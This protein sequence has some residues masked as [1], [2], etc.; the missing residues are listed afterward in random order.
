MSVTTN[1]DSD[2]NRDER[3]LGEASALLE[4]DDLDEEIGHSEESPLSAQA[5]ALR[6]R[7]DQ[8]D[9]NSQYDFGCLLRDGVGVEKNFSESVRYFKMAADQG[10][11]DAQLNC[12]QLLES[13]VEPNLSEAARYYKLAADQGNRDAQ[14]AYALCLQ[15][16]KGVTKDSSEMARY[17]KLGADQDS[18]DCQLSY[19]WCLFTGDGVVKDASE[20]ARYFK[21][22]ADGNNPDGQNCFGCC[23]A[24]GIGVKRNLPE[25]VRYFKLS[26]DMGNADGQ[27]NFGLCR[28]LGLGMEQNE[29]E[30]VEYFKRSADKG[31]SGGQDS[32][33]W[34]LL[35]GIGLDGGRKSADDVE[36]AAQCFKNS[37][38]QNNSNGQNSYGWCRANGIG[39]R[40][41]LSDAME[42]FKK[43]ADQG[44]PIGQL[45]YG[46]TIQSCVSESSDKLQEA[47]ESLRKSGEQ[48]YCHGWI[49]Y[50][51]CLE[52][53][54]GIEKDP[55]GAA[56]ILKMLADQGS[57]ERHYF[58]L[59]DTDNCVYV[60]EQ[61]PEDS[62]LVRD[63]MAQLYY[64]R[65]LELGLG[66]GKDLVDA[67][68]YYKLSAEQGNSYGAVAFGR[69]LRHGIGV[70]QDPYLASGY[71]DR[72]AR[73]GFRNVCQFGKLRYAIDPG[74]GCIWHEVEMEDLGKCNLKEYAEE[75]TLGRGSFG[76]V[77]RRRHR[78]SGN[79]IAV[80]QVSLNG[81]RH[82]PSE[83]RAL[84]SLRHPSILRIFD[85]VMDDK[86][87]VAS[88]VTEVLKNQSLEK[89]L[90][91]A[92]NQEAPP[93]WKRENIVIMI[94]GLIHGMRYTH[95]AGIAH[96][97]LKPANLLI[98]DVYRIRIADFGLAKFLTSDSTSSSAIGT[99][100][101]AGPEIFDGKSRTERVDI[102]AFGLILYEVLAG[103]SI[104][105]DEACFK[106]IVKW[107]NVR[108]AL[109][110]PRTIDPVVCKLI[111]D[112]L[113]VNPMDRPGFDEIYERMVCAGF[114]LY[115]DV[116]YDTVREFLMELDG[117]VRNP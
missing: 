102:F 115:P 60:A 17:W 68:Q 24:C 69:C 1:S 86:K 21:L 95:R 70:G 101:Y 50:A 107:H 113:S 62:D 58:Y 61:V 33:G 49:H 100:K 13:G 98:D 11:S 78:V 40:K 4:S 104:F 99:A 116:G 105:G 29:N 79:L 103:H 117:Q 2:G 65:C 14:M 54:V 81:V 10:H 39:V 97:D 20:A 94:A 48:G 53:G 66:V 30:G 36:K 75:G 51:F 19:G 84:C 85:Y 93:F 106:D 91:L 59:T 46:L 18:A 88:I 3:D 52:N 47:V 6:E 31:S 89:A 7:A 77:T 5:M 27:G 63:D 82:F 76:A 57:H 41:N 8:G 64:G 25:A 74:P 22:S 72:S 87:K 15:H 90:A 109:D 83:I 56:R 43:S 108:E 92:K 55:V 37:A 110:F 111:E 112:C 23:L 96:R 38:D 12:A 9:R 35:N 28:F 32:Y 67:A 80:K 114:P 16:E 34:C 44:N 26:A 42:Y 71:F 73:N 45:N